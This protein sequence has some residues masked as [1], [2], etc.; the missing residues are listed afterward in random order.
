MAAAPLPWIVAAGAPRCPIA[1]STSA[2]D[3]LPRVTGRDNVDAVIGALQAAG[4]SHVELALHNV[5]PAPP[6]TAPFMG[7]TP[8]YP[9]RVVLTPEQVAAINADARSALRAWR[10]RA[11]PAVFEDVRERFASAGLHVLACAA[12]F[13][14]SFTD[15]EIDATFRQVGA[16]GVSTVAS[17]L[18]MKM[19]RRLAPFAERHTISV[20]IHTQ[21]NGNSAGAIAP[22]DL[23]D[24]LALSR[25]FALKLDTGSLTASN[26]DAVAVLRQH[27]DRVWA[28]LASDRLR[29][30]GAHQPLGEGDTPLAGVLDVVAAAP[31]PIP[32][33]VG[34][35]Y[36]GL[37]RAPDEVKASLRYVT[38]LLA[39]TK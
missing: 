7:G 23:S 18:T 37:R 38:G 14:D 12:R 15:E 2:F 3:E 17:A 22:A 11:A 16:F 8:A 39:H 6:A 29:N 27:L 33:L 25:R 30:G 32:V 20:A 10:L 13:D 1:V 26:M 31:N 9:Q 34:Y 28:V 5:D 24:A 35:D 19:A 4:A 21:V 36:I